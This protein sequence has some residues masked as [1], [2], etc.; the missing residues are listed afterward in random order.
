MY[1]EDDRRTVK[2]SFASSDFLMGLKREVFI[3]IALMAVAWQCVEWSA[4]GCGHFI[5][6]VDGIEFSNGLCAIHRYMHI[7]L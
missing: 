2:F 5:I 7:N 1:L 3:L 4:A 6:I